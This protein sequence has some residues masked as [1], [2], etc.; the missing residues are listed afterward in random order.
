MASALEAMVSGHS[1]V[2]ANVIR[3]YTAVPRDSAGGLCTPD[4]Q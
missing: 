4:G 2:T 1:C 3:S